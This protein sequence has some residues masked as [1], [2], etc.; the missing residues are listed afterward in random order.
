MSQYVVESKLSSVLQRPAYDAGTTRPMVS[1]RLL[2]VTEAAHY[3]SVST[4]SVRFLIR[5]NKL[6]VVRLPSARGGRATR[7]LLIDLRD[8]DKLIER[9]RG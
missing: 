5:S 6:P 3:L 1:K 4:D 7:K 2:D 8:L 9:S